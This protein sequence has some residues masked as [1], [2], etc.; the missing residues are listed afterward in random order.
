MKHHV[1]SGAIDVSGW[2]LE[3]PACHSRAPSRKTVKIES[4]PVYLDTSAL[5]KLYVQETDSDALDSALV[6]RQDLL[7]S[8]LVLT[9]LTSVLTRRI[10]EGALA[11]ATGRRIYQQVFRDVRAGEYRLLDLTP[12]THREAE[13]LLLAIGRHAPIRAADSLHLATA[14][15]AEARC[16]V[17]YDRQM[18]AAASTL[19]SFEVLPPELPAA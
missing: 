5:A 9:E 15:L 7:I 1:P 17:T 6:G 2:P 11:P 19:G 14:A 12:A 13:R 18:H 16:L 10:R 8:E 4:S 3:K